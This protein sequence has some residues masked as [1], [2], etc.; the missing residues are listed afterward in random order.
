VGGDAV[1]A[2]L[3]RRAGL[4][5]RRAVTSVVVDRILGLAIVFLMTAFGLPWLIELIAHPGMRTALVVIAIGGIAGLAVLSQLDRL[6]RHL[7]TWGVVRAIEA[8]AVDFRSVISSGRIVEIAAYS[9]AVQVMFALSAFAIATGL[10]LSV[11]A[12]QCLVLI[13]PVVLAMAI[14]ISVAG[15]GVREGAMVVTFGFIGVDSHDALAL[16]VLIGAATL[17]ASLP[18]ALVWLAAGRPQPERGSDAEEPR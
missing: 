12:W 18:G 11:S 1:R 3:I 5:T 2:W 14:P 8:L 4:A 13:P 17:L 9:I 16:S 6:A 7:P 10:G 15:W